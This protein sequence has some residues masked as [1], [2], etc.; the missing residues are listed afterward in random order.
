[1]FG[2]LALC[3]A[4]FL[5]FAWVVRRG[6]PRSMA[7]LPREAVAVLG[8]MPLAKGQHAS[9]IQVGN[10]LL[11]VAV[12]PAGAE[13]LTEIDDPAEVDRLRTICN[14]PA[15]ENVAGKSFRMTLQRFA[16]K[17]GV[18]VDPAA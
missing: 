1:M 15:E 3:L 6:M 11:L 16:G 10:K 12:S 7:V 9:L 8:R 18:S 14:G 2:G 17:S 5:A 13:T 4:L